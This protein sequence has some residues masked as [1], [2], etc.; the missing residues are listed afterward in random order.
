MAAPGFW[1]DPAAAQKVAQEVDGLRDETEGFRKL[2]QKTEDLATLWEMATEEQDD[3][4]LKEIEEILTAAQT[5]LAHLEI[6]MLLCEEYDKNN[7][8]FLV[9]F[10]SQKVPFLRDFKIQKELL[11]AILIKMN[12]ANNEVV[13]LFL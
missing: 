6:G 1:D 4:Y 9:F 3:S 13:Y 5:E 10:L 8:I 12:V 11:F 7:A 2:E